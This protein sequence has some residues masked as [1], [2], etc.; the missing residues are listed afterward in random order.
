MARAKKIPVS[1]MNAQDH[2]LN[3]LQE[4]N[5]PTQQDRG[6]LS[7]LQRG[8]GQGIGGILT[9][10]ERVPSP[11]DESFL[12]HLGALGG[13][14]VSDIPGML[15]GGEAGAALGS[16]FGPGGAIVGGASGAFALPTL[17]NQ[18]YNEYV[19]A[20]KSNKDLSF[21]DFLERASRVGVETGKAAATGAVAGQIGKYVPILKNIPGFGRIL[22]TK[23]G[24]KAAEVA[25]ETAGITGAQAA[26]EGELPSLQNVAD[27]AA[28][29]TGA[30]VAHGAARGARR[31]IEKIP[32][33]AETLQAAD[34]LAR[35]AIEKTYKKAGEYAPQPVTD[36]FNKIKDFSGGKQQKEL[37][38][39]LKENIGERNARTIDSQFNWKER[40][41]EAQKNG[42]FTPQQL[43]DMIYY[44]QKTG[45]PKVAQD[46]YEAIKKRLPANAREFVD[47]VIDKHLKDSL[48]EWNENPVTKKINP[49][50]GLEEIYLPG[51]YE[52]DAQKFPR[53]Y[54]EVS[55]RFKAKNPFSNPKTFLNYVDAFEKYGLK[56]R[57]KNVVDLMRAYDSIMNKSLASQ[58]ILQSIKEYEKNN[59]QKLVVTSRNRK[60]Y[61]NA[62]KA[63]WIPFD[64]PYLRRY[65]AGTK[66]TRTPGQIGE[67]GNQEFFRNLSPAEVRQAQSEGYRNVPAELG[68]FTAK[69]EKGQPIFATTAAPALVHPDFAQA[70]QGVF[71][72]NAYRPEH[73]FWKA[74]DSLGDKIRF[75]RV[76]FSPFH[77]GAL[78]E[79]ALGALGPKEALNI[80]KWTKGA[81]ELRNNREWQK[82]AARA[83]LTFHRPT[84][85]IGQRGES[86]LSKG[87]QYL[88]EKRT[89]GKGLKAIEKG[90][91]YL[92][93]EFQPNLKAITY[94]TLSQ[95]ALKDAQQKGQPFNE[96]TIRQEVAEL[97][98]DIYGGQNW[99]VQKVFNNPETRKWMR[100]VIGYPD[101]TTSAIK[102]FA[103]AFNPGLK[104]EQARKYWLKYGLSY[105]TLQGF[106]KF[107]NGGF[108]QTDPDMSVK[109]VKWNP[110]K[111][112]DALVN[113]DPSKWA[114]FGLPDIPVKI[115]NSVINPGRTSYG[116]KLYGH[117]GKSAR[118]IGNWI[119]HPLV[120]FFNKA[121]PLIQATLGQ[122]LEYRPGKD[123]NYP[124]RPKF[125]DHK[126]VPWDGT[127][128]YTTGRAI[129]RGK[130][131]LDHLVPFGVKSLVEGEPGKFVGSG[132]GLYPVSQGLSLQKADKYL[133]KAFTSN[134]KELLARVIKSLRENQKS[135]KQIKA[136]IERVRRKIRAQ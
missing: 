13:Q 7:A 92:F 26:L 19:D 84:S 11:R 71:N 23:V 128:P 83:G 131:L 59:N 109:G 121:N 14:T 67:Y 31:G 93:D 6:F 72:K 106:L 88:G 122:V 135:E 42:E 9:G 53:A 46:S 41:A 101:W 21:G 120:E 132:L 54:E 108:E 98:N 86:L 62:K 16:P 104:G 94:E 110:E 79:H 55:R 117:F 4:L 97:V 100:R 78:L 44:R 27:I 111:A 57:Y 38:N 75:A 48:R 43:E 20:T 113:G 63:G 29:S 37:F 68:D 15:L 10:Q 123:K 96:N 64:D 8:F 47:N 60:A 119:Q 18:A 2:S 89:A 65:V 134:D 99:E 136:H 95:E 24:T 74:Y 124:I 3:V 129:S 66:N 102:T 52:Y 25:L 115:G 76:S 49:R 82:Q 5:P 87:A 61:E 130:D 85:E 126:E 17:L 90:M 36:L 133:E 91:S 118:E 73:P 56:P 50:E 105:M 45:N 103:D 34:Q 77:Y 33:G 116:T 1:R 30:K 22:N 81:Q 32:Y 58:E 28:L 107:M 80:P 112:Y 125:V 40:L 51:L 114:D 12:E 70:F 35:N 69:K 127:E 39:I